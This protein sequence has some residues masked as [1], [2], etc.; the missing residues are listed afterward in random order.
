GH[1]HEYNRIDPTPGQNPFPVIVG[2]GYKLDSATVMIL[3]RRGDEMTLTVFGAD[4]R[5]IDTISL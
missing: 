3:R 4:G 5:T 1:T 2:G